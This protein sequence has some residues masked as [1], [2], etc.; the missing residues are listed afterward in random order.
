MKRLAKSATIA[1]LI[2]GMSVASIA[3][4]LA[5]R[6]TRYDR[7]HLRASRQL[8]GIGDKGRT[9]R[10]GGIGDKG[11]TYY[12]TGIG[13]KGRTYSINGIGDKGRTG[14]LAQ[15]DQVTFSTFSRLLEYLNFSA[16]P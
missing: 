3:P 15:V 10:L 6:A 8:D 12:L 14:H 4:A 11:R 1:A 13:D 16:R 2:A 7:A 5:G 9:Y